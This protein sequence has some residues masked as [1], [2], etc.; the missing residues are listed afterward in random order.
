MAECSLLILH[1]YYHDCSLLL[2]LRTDELFKQTLQALKGVSVLQCEILGGRKCSSPPAMFSF[3]HGRVKD[4]NV[5]S[6]MRVPFG[7]FILF[8][9]KPCT[10]VPT[11]SEMFP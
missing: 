5:R 3:K 6:L 11:G 2:L 1:L 10:C 7:R 4:G 8:Y 9:S